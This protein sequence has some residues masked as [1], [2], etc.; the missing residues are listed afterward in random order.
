MKM[1]TFL[2]SLANIF[3]TDRFNTD[4]SKHIIEITSAINIFG[5]L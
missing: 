1:F 2:A 4:N 5:N 3:S